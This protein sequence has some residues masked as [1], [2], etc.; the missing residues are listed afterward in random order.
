MVNVFLESFLTPSIVLVLLLFLG[1]DGEGSL[2]ELLDHRNSVVQL[3]L[4]KQVNTVARYRRLRAHRHEVV[5]EPVDHHA[6]VALRAIFPDFLE[7]RFAAF[8]GDPRNVGRIK[9]SCAADY[10]DLAEFA[11]GDDS[12]FC[13]P[14]DD[15]ANNDFDVGRL[16]RIEKDFAGRK[17]STSNGILRRKFLPQD[18]VFYLF[19]LGEGDFAE[20][21]LQFRFGDEEV[22]PLFAANPELG[23]ESS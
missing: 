18:G 21:G 2:L 12:S 9:P 13:D 20:A 6:L 4:D 19:E 14:L 1:I 8:N 7:R 17:T 11:F 5:G 23:N 10:V 16:D 3:L 22:V 15:V